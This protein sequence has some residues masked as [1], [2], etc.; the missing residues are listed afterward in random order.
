MRL[1][2]T[3]CSRKT[4]ISGGVMSG[5]LGAVA[6]GIL[7]YK[8]FTTITNS[9]GEIKEPNKNAGRAIIISIA[10]C[11]VVYL[12][13]ILAVGGNLSI[14]EIIEAKDYPRIRSWT[15]HKVRDIG[16]DSVRPHGRGR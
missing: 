13:V 4:E 5:F 15:R 16:S 8:A 10:I 12:L 1:L 9:G 11:V 3:H 2:A 7:A 14:D 6:L